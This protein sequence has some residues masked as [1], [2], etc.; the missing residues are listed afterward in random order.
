M[1]SLGNVFPVIFF[2]VAA[3]VSLTAMTR[4]VDE[5]RMSMGILK[6]LGYRSSAISGKYL[7]YALLAT[8]SGGIIGIAI[9][10]RFLPLLIIKS[11]G[12]LFT[13]IPYCMT[14]IN[15]EQAFLALLAA[16][17]ST[18]AATLFSALS[19]LLENPASLMRPLQALFGRDLI[20]QGRLLSET[21]PD[22]RKG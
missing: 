1:D 22:T 19:Q 18:V 12:T 14:P 8:V 7:A 10:E 13:G 4:M 20:L 9:G 2:L 21:L 5:N 11:Y 15:Y 3:L 16:T 6:A 17:A